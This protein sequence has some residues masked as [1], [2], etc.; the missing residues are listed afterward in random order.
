MHS[1]IKLLEFIYVK[2]DWYLDLIQIFFIIILSDNDIARSDAIILQ[3]IHHRS[4]SVN[5]AL[6]LL[7]MAFVWCP[8]VDKIGWIQSNYVGDSLFSGD[9]RLMVGPQ[10]TVLGVQ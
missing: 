9:S 10:G 8:K 7:E 2:S 5:F 4:N 1:L 3:E 6:L